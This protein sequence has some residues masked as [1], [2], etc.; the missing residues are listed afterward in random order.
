MSTLTT[1]NFCVNGTLDAK[2]MTTLERNW[3]RWEENIIF[4]L[5]KQEGTL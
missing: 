5:K 2:V 3:C 4:N 1:V